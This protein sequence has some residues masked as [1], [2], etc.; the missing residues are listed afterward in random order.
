MPSFSTPFLQLYLI[1]HYTQLKGRWSADGKIVYF[2]REHAPLFVAAVA[3]LLFLWIPYTL[4]VFAGQWLHR[5]E[6]CIINHLLLQL[7]PFLH[8]HIAAFKPRHRHW[9][10]LLLVVRATILLT[11]AVIPTDN[12]K[13]VVNLAALSSILLI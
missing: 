11:T 1:Q 5:L 3:T 4:L 8:A 6:F 9:F 12:V 10:G 7:K 2:S 13:I